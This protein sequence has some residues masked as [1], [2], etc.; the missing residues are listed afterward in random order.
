MNAM[1]GGP[2][3]LAVLMVTIMAVGAAAPAW[4]QADNQTQGQPSAGK[5]DNDDQLRSIGS[6]AGRIATQPVKDVGLSRKDIP[7]VLV[8]AA[9]NPYG[10]DGARTCTQIAQSVTA[11]NEVLGPDYAPDGPKTKENRA[12][13]LAEA[14]GQTIVNSLI[15]FRGL[16][17]EVSGAASAQRQMNATV[18]AGLARRGFLRG[19][20][21]ARRCK[22]TF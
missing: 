11:L 13:K 4:A 20:H 9:I 14:G 21:S 17:R 3:G 2:T 10:L 8:A 1:S 6:G 16:V 22:T 12:G 7:P 5:P 18:D 19:L 15:P